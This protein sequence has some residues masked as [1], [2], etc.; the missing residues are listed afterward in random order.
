MVKVRELICQLAVRKF[1]YTGVSVARFLGVTSSLVNRYAV[2]GELPE[3][4][5]YA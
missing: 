3:L 2:S 4:R 1:G 5:G